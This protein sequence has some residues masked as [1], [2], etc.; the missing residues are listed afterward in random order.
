[1]VFDVSSGTASPLTQVSAGGT[2]AI[3]DLLLDG[4][5]Q[6][7]NA[8]GHFFGTT[9][10]GN[11]LTIRHIRSLHGARDLTGLKD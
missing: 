10:F 5:V 2:L 4:G 1:M 9:P 8:H 7:T 11:A 6:V 3:T